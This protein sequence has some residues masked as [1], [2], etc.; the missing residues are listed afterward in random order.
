MG[1]WPQARHLGLP[2]AGNRFRCSTEA[3]KY[4]WPRQWS[5]DLRWRSLIV[6]E[7]LSAGSP[8]PAARR[9]IR[10]PVT[11]L[12]CDHDRTAGRTLPGFDGHDQQLRLLCFFPHRLKRYDGPRKAVKG[13]LSV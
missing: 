3:T 13:L 8:L 9:P 12:G 7:A 4:P 2:F 10:F 11:V 1:M 5:I 6:D